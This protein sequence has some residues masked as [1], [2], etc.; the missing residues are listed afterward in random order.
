[1]EGNDPKS[2]HRKKVQNYLKYSGF[3]IQFFVLVLIGA[4]LGKRLDAYFGLERPLITIFLILFFSGGY[5]YKL[6]IDLFK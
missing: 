6:Y 3:A 5:F 2:K 1:M 4:L